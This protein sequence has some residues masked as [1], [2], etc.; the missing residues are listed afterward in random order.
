M[1]SLHLKALKSFVITCCVKLGCHSMS[2]RGTSH[3]GFLLYRARSGWSTACMRY[4][5]AQTG[6]LVLHACNTH[7][8]AHLQAVHQILCT[9]R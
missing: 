2:S 5:S 1:A 4:G 3:L 6:H 9:E 7:D 8:M